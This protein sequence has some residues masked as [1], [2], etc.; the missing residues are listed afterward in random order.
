MRVSTVGIAVVQGI[1]GAS[2]VADLLD[3]HELRTGYRQEAM[4]NAALSFSGKA[5][6][7]VG[8]ILGGLIITAISFPTNVAPADVPAEAILR[9]GV[10]VGAMV[11]LLY[12]FP[13]SLIT[14]YRLTR[15]RHAEIR[16]ALDAR[17]LEQE[18]S[19]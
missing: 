14:R 4:F 5:V 6:S 9:L 16:A 12:L 10:V 19:P 17:R 7:G 13:I 11:P 1:I 3:D 8:T 2:I 18:Q 15:D